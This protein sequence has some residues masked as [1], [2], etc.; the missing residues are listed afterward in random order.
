[1][2]PGRYVLTINAGLP[3]V[4]NLARLENVLSFDIEDTAE[5]INNLEFNRLGPQG[6]KTAR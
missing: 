2:N 4:K 5:L 6:T 1:M 3:G